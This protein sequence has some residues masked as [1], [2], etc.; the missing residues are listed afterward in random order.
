MDYSIVYSSG[1]GNTE[2]LAEAIKEVLPKQECKYFGVSEGEEIQT[3]LVFAG[4]WT[5]QGTCDSAAKAFLKTL[6]NKDVFLFGTAGFGGN[7]EYYD[8]ILDAVNK[9]LGLSNKIVGTYMCQGKMP[10]TVRK[11]YEKT[12]AENPENY[13][14]QDMIDNFDRA[15]THPDLVDC[16]RI[17]QKVRTLND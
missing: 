16:N 15:A 4:F 8:K 1:T 7:Q 9:N 3:K 11:R 17:K 10:N 5:N 6:K 2:I 13:N 12:L 14:M